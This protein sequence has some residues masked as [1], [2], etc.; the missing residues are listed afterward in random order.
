MRLGHL[1]FIKQ[2]ESPGRNPIYFSYGGWH[3]TFHCPVHT[4]KPVKLECSAESDLLT[5][6]ESIYEQH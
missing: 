2:P 3:Y 1:S 5:K 4:H 6:S